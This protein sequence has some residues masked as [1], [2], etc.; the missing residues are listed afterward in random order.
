MSRIPRSSAAEQRG[1]ESV[2]EQVA[3]IAEEMRTR[4]SARIARVPL[5]LDRPALVDGLAA[6]KHLRAR[7]LLLIAR[8]FGAPDPEFSAEAGVALELLHTASLVH[9]DII[10]GSE[11]RRGRP[12]VH[13]AADE[14]T[15]ILLADLLIALAFEA[16]APMGEPVTASLARAFAHLCEGQLMEPSLGWGADARQGIEH[17]A[18]L[19]TGALFG[20]AFEIGGVAA[21]FDSAHRDAFREAG[22]RLGLAFQLSDDLLDVRGDALAL[23]KDAGADIRNGVPTIPLWHAYRALE[24]A[25]VD[26]EDPRFLERLAEEAASDGVLSSTAARVSELVEECRARLPA[27]AEPEALDLAVSTVLAGLAG[28]P[29]SHSPNRIEAP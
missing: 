28:T 12:T 5:P 9:D 11:L 13:R 20:A 15:A 26:P 2:D 3:G 16:A 8:A 24:G 17:Y 6:G 14:P 4:I 7:T 19:K 22:T 27:A 21:G 25:G 1:T 23:G 18:S 10:D 29:G